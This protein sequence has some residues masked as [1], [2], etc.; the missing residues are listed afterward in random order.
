MPENPAE[1]PAETDGGGSGG[2]FRFPHGGIGGPNELP[3]YEFTR[4]SVAQ[5]INEIFRLRNRLNTLENNFLAAKLQPRSAFFGG[6]IGGPNE[7]PEGEGGGSGG[8]VI[9]HEI[10]EINELPI[11]R[12]V[13]ELSSLVARFAQFERN[14]LQQLESISARVNAIKK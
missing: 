2:G 5:L 1:I 6:G 3:P 10:H 11:S 8:G 4:V 12:F 7:L 14:V 9:P 13:A